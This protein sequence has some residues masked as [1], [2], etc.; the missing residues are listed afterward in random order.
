MVEI[1]VEEAA[2]FVHGSQ[3]K[4]HRPAESSAGP[5]PV[6]MQIIWAEVQS[7]GEEAACQILHSQA[8]YSDA[9]VLARARRPLRHLS[10]SR[11]H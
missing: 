3:G 4:Q 10:C 9:C 8:L 6:Q 5:P 2:I 7:P 11:L 1:L